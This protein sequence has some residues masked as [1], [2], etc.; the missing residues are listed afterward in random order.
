MRNKFSA[1]C[2]K[3][4]KQVDAG[5]GETN[6][7]DGKW[8]TEH[9]NADACKAAKSSVPRR[10]GASVGGGFFGSVYW[11]GSDYMEDEYD[12]MWGGTSEDVNPLEGC[13]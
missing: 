10:V 7:V 4:G 3:C 6:K 5:A 9:L 2:K 12:Y 8:H 13:K 1:T 11:S